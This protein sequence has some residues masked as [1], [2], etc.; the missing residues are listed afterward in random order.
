MRF[1]HIADVHLGRHPDIGTRWEDNSYREIYDSFE[2]FIDYLDVNSVDF[3]F[4]TGDLFDFVPGIQELTY[5]DDQFLKL[6]DTNIIYVTGEADYLKRGAALWNYSFLSRLYILDSEPIDDRLLTEVER[7]AYADKIVDCLYF[8]KFNMDIYGVCQYSGC[9]ER[10]DLDTIYVHNDK[11]I[12]ILLAHG[13]DEKVC[14]FDTDDFVSKTFNYVG[15]G[16]IH[17]Y[18]ENIR[19][20]LYYPGSLEPLSADETGEHGFIRGY[21]DRLVTD[22]RLVP[23]ADRKYENIEIPVSDDMSD[24][25]LA[26]E[27]S[28]RC[29]ENKNHIYTIKLIREDDCYMDFSIDGLR[30][31]YRILDILGD[32]NNRISPDRLEALNKEN[33]IGKTL[34]EIR[35]IG[36]KYEK[37]AAAVYADKM[38]RIIWGADN[39]GLISQMAD[40]K[41]AEAAQKRLEDD[42]KEELERLYQGVCICDGEEKKLD[43]RRHRHDDI[44][45]QRNVIRAKYGELEYELSQ[46]NY[47][48]AQINR[49]YSMNRIGFIGKLDFPIIILI[50]LIATAGAVLTFFWRKWDEW[51]N[52]ILILICVVVSVSIISFRIYNATKGIRKRLKGDELPVEKHARLADKR[53]EIER[54]MHETDIEMNRCELDLKMLGNIVDEQ[55]KMKKRRKKLAE[56]CHIYE[57]IAAA[58]GISDKKNLALTLE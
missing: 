23:F 56:R 6:R 55:E 9:N 45:G 36:G 13:G 18:T 46:I 5:V 17:N 1:A 48:E 38:A 47:E 4:I 52:I 35:R 40:I 7:T 10:N 25:E 42:I 12:N 50:L 14:P 8:K 27:I 44:V 16:H 26:A 51:L 43:E 22:V 11:R 33:V 49:I 30:K 24:T 58:S 57:N 37:Q 39:L 54:L 21:V 2:R 3:L 29:S 19:A 28:M 20:R 15:V 34:C 31:K 41:R 32:K 53:T